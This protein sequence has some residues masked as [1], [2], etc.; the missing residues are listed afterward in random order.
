MAQLQER[1]TYL[2]GAGFCDN[3]CIVGVLENSEK[4]DMNAF[5]PI[6]LK[7]GLG[8]D[9]IGDFEIQQVHRCG[10]KPYSEASYRQH[11]LR[12]FLRFSVRELVLRA[13]QEYRTFRQYLSK[14]TVQKFKNMTKSN[15]NSEQ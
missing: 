12:K 14:D 10:P 8:L 1:V 6:L 7:E 3:V 15:A 4:R 9:I 11:I 5:V 2:E 13:A